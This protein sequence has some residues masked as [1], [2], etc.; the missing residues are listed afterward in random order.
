MPLDYLPILARRRA[1]APPRR[2]KRIKKP[3]WHPL[4]KP[5]GEMCVSLI[6]STAIRERGQPPFPRSRDASYRKIR[7][8][9]AV[10]SLRVDHRS[11]FGAPVRKDPETVFPAKA[12][13]TAAG[14]GLVGSVASFHFSIYGGIEL[15]REIEESLAP[16]LANELAKARVDLAVLVPY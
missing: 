9:A 12:L 13:K 7:S 5:L 6:T 8:D 10:T 11:P 2:L 14:G 3:A 16:A 15:Y 1:P 4:S